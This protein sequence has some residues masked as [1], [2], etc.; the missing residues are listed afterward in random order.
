M[1]LRAVVTA[2]GVVLVVAASGCGGV[3][4]SPLTIEGGV[5]LGGDGGGVRD[6]AADRSIPTC[7]WPTALDWEPNTPLGCFAS[8]TLLICTGGPDGGLELTLDGAMTNAVTVQCLSS[9][10]NTCENDAGPPSPDASA[11]TACE[12]LCAPTEYAVECVAQ[13]ASGPPSPPAGTACH[14]PNGGLVSADVTFLCCACG[15]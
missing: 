8:R 5:G 7:S 3:V 2:A 9:G 11:L 15:E 10:L 13:G 4:G 14:V 12:D 6:A 1:T